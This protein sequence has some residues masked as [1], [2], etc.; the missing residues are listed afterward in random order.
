M[1]AVKILLCYGQQKVVVLRTA[2]ERALHS[3]VSEA[4]DLRVQS[5]YVLQSFNHD[6]DEFV[7]I[8]DD[9]IPSHKEKIK[10]RPQY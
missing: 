1:E 8:P 4:F 7:D 6:F 5:Q 2:D 10:V 3:A 9:F